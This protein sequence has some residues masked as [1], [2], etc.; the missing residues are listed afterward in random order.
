MYILYLDDSGSPLNPAEDHFVLGG[1]ALFERKTYWIERDLNALAEAVAPEGVESHD[2]EFHASAIR[3]GKEAHWKGI[4]KPERVKIIGNVLQILA[5]AGRGAVSFAVA[6]HKPSYPH[7]DPVELAFE[8][9]MN[10]FD[11]LLKRLHR[12]DNTQRGLIVMDNTTKKQTFRSLARHFKS[13]G[14]RWGTL[15]NIVEA[16]FFVDSKVSRPMQLAD[17]LAYAV[18]RRY[19]YGDASLL[20]LVAHTFDCEGPRVHGLLHKQVA[21][22]NCRC[23]ACVGR[24]A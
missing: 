7:S 22:G 19:Q 13:L 6:V 18:F 21:L 10:R 20:D 15:K 23:R 1:V 11:L 3:R 12:D 17:H 14:T 9:L 8:E 2:L 5:D 16:P 4:P 24:Q